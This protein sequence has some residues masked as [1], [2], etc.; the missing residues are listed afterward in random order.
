MFFDRLV[1]YNHHQKS[2]YLVSTD[3]YLINQTVD[4]EAALDDIENRLT[5]PTKVDIK[6]TLRFGIPI[7]DNG[8][9]GKNQCNYH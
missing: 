2:A 4:H 9:L 5:Q 6:F 3:S 7:T 8:L 1:I